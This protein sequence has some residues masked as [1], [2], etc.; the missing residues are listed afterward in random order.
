MKTFLISTMLIF[1]T[2]VLAHAYFA[3]DLNKPAANVITQEKYQEEEE[4]LQRKE[5]IEREN[6]KLPKSKKS[7][8]QPPVQE[9]V[10][11]AINER[12]DIEESEQAR[13]PY[14]E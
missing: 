13:E 12:L 7:T 14:T 8:Q 9:E 5:A 4:K 6:A 3:E 2:T 11:E 1:C 10:S